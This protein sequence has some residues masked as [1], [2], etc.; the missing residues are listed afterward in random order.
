MIVEFEAWRS[1]TSRGMKEETVAVVGKSNGRS[2]INSSRAF[3][4]IYR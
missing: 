4:S 2:S 1:S 3:H